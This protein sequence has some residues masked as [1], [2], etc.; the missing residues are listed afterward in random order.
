M[1]ETKFKEEGKLKVD[2][3]VVFE[4]VRKTRDG[5]GGGIASGCIKEL[6]PVLVR[7]GVKD[8]KQCLL[9]FWLNVH[10]SHKSQFIKHWVVQFCFI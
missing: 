3:F 5:G 4:H 6:K 8:W 2:N 1:E 7:K 9:T 10:N